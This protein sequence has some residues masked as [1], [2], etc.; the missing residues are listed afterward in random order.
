M[1]PDS[2]VGQ[3]A[4]P[5]ARCLRN[6]VVAARWNSWAGSI[7][8]IRTFTSKRWTAKQL[9]LFEHLPDHL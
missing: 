4:H 7:K 1:N 2:V 6:Q 3:V 8:A 9:I 5:S